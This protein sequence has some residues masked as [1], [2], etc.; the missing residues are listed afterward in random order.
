MTEE[1]KYYTG[2]CITDLHTDTYNKEKC[3]Q[4]IKLDG[5]SFCMSSVCPEKD[6]IYALVY[7]LHQ[8][9]DSL[10]QENKELKRKLEL[11]EV[12]LK[13]YFI[14]EEKICKEN[15]KYR[16][17]LEEIREYCKNIADNNKMTNCAMIYEKINEVLNDK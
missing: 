17:V 6:C 3:K 16:S 8:K 14:G 10:E 9:I 15:E 12:Q 7:K 11:D 5:L 4:Y 2:N 1:I 13:S